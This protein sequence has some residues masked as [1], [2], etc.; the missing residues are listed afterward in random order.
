MATAF[1]IGFFQTVDLRGPC[2]AL[3]LI[4]TCG[5]LGREIRVGFCLPRFVFILADGLGLALI[6]W[7][8]IIGM[9]VYSLNHWLVAIGL[10]SHVY[11]GRRFPGGR[12]P[13]RAVARGWA[14]ALAM[15][16][17]GAAGYLW[18]IPTPG[19]TLLRAIP[20]VVSARL[21]LGLVHFVYDRW[22]WKLS[23]P[24]VRATIGRDLFAPACLGQPLP[25]AEVPGSAD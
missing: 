10:S 21:G 3:S 7:Q 1:P 11:A 14:F 17:V 6:W 4:A 24:R 19:G 20:I 8:P 13:W 12:P 15:L 9:A 16:M 18:L 25:R 23:D 2:I 5:M 22:V